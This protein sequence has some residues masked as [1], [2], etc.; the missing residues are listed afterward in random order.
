MK[1]GF[2]GLGNMGTPM[3]ERLL[4]AGHD[5]IVWNRTA[6]RVEPLAGRGARVA[7]TPAEAARGADGV[8]TMV[9]D[10]EALHA[11]VFGPD[12]LASGL[13]AGTALIDMSTVGPDTVRTVA[14]RLPDGV[15]LLDA[16]VRGGPA[17]AAK[18]EL[19]ILL[20]ASEQAAQRWTPVLEILGS[21]THVGPPGAGA[22][23]KVL[24]NFVGVSLVSLLGEAMALADALGIE[25]ARAL[26]L[27]G[28]TPI[29]A[30]LEHQWPRVESGGKPPSFRLRLA[31]KDLR[32][33]LEAADA[34]TDLPMG[35]AALDW[36]VAA[37]E[38]GLGE[39]DQSSVIPHIRSRR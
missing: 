8:I 5:L 36:L 12:G 26:E 20:G 11:V 24:N 16:P 33:A 9:A 14:A 25:E 28:S 18:G 34:T 15:E 19:K 23:A 3:A 35:R 4:D 6:G 21:V 38:A 37:A 27:L 7:A 30:T 1:L 17:R 32:L 10:P 22:A 2:C 13:A 39:H 31:A 29:R